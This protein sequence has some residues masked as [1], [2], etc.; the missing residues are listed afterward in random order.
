M[1]VVGLLR[2][3]VDMSVLCMVSLLWKLGRLPMMAMDICRYNKLSRSLPGLAGEIP[4]QQMEEK[5]N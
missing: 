2:G 4:T 3:L 5:G 1:F